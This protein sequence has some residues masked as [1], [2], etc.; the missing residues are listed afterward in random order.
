[1]TCTSCHPQPQAMAPITAASLRGHT[2][3]QHAQVTS[4]LCVPEAPRPQHTHYHTPTGTR[5]HMH[6]HLH[7]C[8]YVCTLTHTLIHSQ[9]NFHS[10]VLAAWGHYL[11]ENANATGRKLLPSKSILFQQ[12]LIISRGLGL[13][14]VNIFQTLHSSLFSTR[15][16]GLKLRTV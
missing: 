3:P 15:R 11:L 14:S 7:T 12:L 8:T 2:A 5:C 6:T 16:A 10:H 9:A 4:Q 1:M 13:A